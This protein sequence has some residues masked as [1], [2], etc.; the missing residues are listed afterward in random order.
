MK[1][2]HFKFYTHEILWPQKTTK[3][4]MFVVKPPDG[5]DHHL[6]ALAMPRKFRQSHTLAERKHLISFCF[7]KF[8]LLA[9]CFLAQ[10]NLS[11]S[12]NFCAT[13][14][15]LISWSNIRLQIFSQ[16]FGTV[17]SGHGFTTHDHEIFIT[18]INVCIIFSQNFWTMKIWRYMVLWIEHFTCLLERYTQILFNFGS[19][20][21][22]F[23]IQFVAGPNPLVCRCNFNTSPL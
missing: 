17:C 2:N 3:I 14:F 10:N 4:F 19:Y 13:T 6:A 7:E 15:L 20:A 21:K 8:S 22:K 9:K 5:S 16:K 23:H 18:K 1:I 12:S 11:H